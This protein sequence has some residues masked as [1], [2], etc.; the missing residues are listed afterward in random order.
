[1]VQSG[2]TATAEMLRALRTFLKE[3][4]V[5]AYL[6]MMAVCLLE[7]HRTLKPTG[8]LYLHCD[9]TASHYLKV[10]MDAVFGAENFSNELIWKRTTTKND[11]KQGAV[12]WPRVHDVLLMY[13]RSTRIA[14]AAR[15]FQQPFE[16]YD[17]NTI[18]TFYNFKD[19]DGRRY[20]LSDVTAPGQGSR[21]H[22]QYEFKGVTRYWRYSLEKMEQLDVE[23]RIQFRPHGGVPRLKVYL[24]EAP[25]IALGD[26]WTDVRGMHN[27]GT[28]MLGYPTQKPLALLERII[29]ASSKEGD[30][31]LDP[32]CGCGTAIHAAQKLGRQWIGIDI[33]HLAISLIEKRLNDAFPGITYRVHGTPRDIDGARALAQADKYEFQWWAV[34]LVN[35]VPYGGKKKGADSGIDGHIYFKPDGKTTEKAIVSVKGGENVS[36]PMIREL[37][38]VVE[39]EKAKIGLFITL[40]EPTKPMQTEAIKAGFY[41]TPY[42]KFP[43]IQVLTIEEL[44]KGK[45]PQL[46]WRDPSSFRQ[47]RRE[48]TTQQGKLF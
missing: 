20:R 28:E 4:D 27:L 40:A 10:L 41:E 26:V 45:K 7:L 48:D 11:Y 39:R 8:S 33:T 19:P 21:G 38:H 17:E 37:G 24:D 35:A 2:N 16:A 30:N 44:F 23:G 6:T 42:G 13:H 3:N 46:P 29:N 12:N 31:V 14:R 5:M 18:A 22:P 32:F 25:G 15:T 43:K 47:A 9:P 34:S 1:V 36:I